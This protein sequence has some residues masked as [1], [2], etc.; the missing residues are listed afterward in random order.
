MRAFLESIT[1][2]QMAVILFIICLF[3]IASW[4]YFFAMEND[5]YKQRSHRCRYC[6]KFT[7]IGSLFEGNCQLDR[8]KVLKD[9]T[10]RHF[11]PRNVLLRIL[12][13]LGF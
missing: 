4:R 13:R 10:C 2:A 12:S 9:S 3:F 7:G 11:Y 5:V 6:D 8:Q 1:P